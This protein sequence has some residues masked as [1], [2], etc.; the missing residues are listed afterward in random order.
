M[1]VLSMIEY[2]KLP[3]VR[4]TAPDGAQATVTLFG[5][6][7]V[8]W[9]G[10]DGRERL[11]V[12]S[13]SALDGSAAIRGGVPVVFPQFGMRGNGPRHGIARTSH[14]RLGTSG[15]QAGLAFAEFVLTDADVPA[16]LAAAWPFQFELRFKVAVQANTVEM[17]FAVHNT[18]EQE[19]A[20]AAA[21]HTYYA[22]AD[23]AA[24]RIDG[25]QQLR[26]TDY[27]MNDTRQEEAT[28][29][30]DGKIDRIYYQVP[31][32][33]TV[34]DGAATLR[35]E[36]DGF[37]D[38]VVWNPGAADALAMADLADAEY[39]DFVCVEALLVEPAALAPGATWVGQHRVIG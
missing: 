31:G 24:L 22:V 37:T 34:A 12:S 19:F 29:R 15:Q 14:W 23:L 32:A 16:E 8:S 1:T 25:L 30:I 11:F 28:L 4:I 7:L 20:F 26:Y 18:G 33:V 36:Q 21:L 35:L 9:Q 2:D 39:Q 3:A 17:S 13:R 6:H 27:L 10:A 38:T 5:A